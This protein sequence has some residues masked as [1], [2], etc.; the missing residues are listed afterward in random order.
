[1]LGIWHCRNRQCMEDERRGSHRVPSC[2]EI[3]GRCCM[4]GSGFRD[5][6]EMKR[7]INYFG[8][9]MGKQYDRADQ[10]KIEGNSL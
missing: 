1:M 3:M 5:G 8:E 6:L 4:K 2:D 7:E 9:E 10:R